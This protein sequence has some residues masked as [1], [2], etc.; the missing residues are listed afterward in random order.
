MDVNACD[1]D[2]KTLE[3]PPRP[4]ITEGAC[5]HLSCCGFSTLLTLMRRDSEFINAWARA[6]KP[7]GVAAMNVL[8]SDPALFAT[9]LLR[10]RTAFGG[11]AAYSTQQLD[12]L[13]HAPFRRPLQPL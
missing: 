2:D 7:G 10:I 9:I 1:E 6:T 11:C 3:A 13:K 8:C 5:L 4:F 12:S